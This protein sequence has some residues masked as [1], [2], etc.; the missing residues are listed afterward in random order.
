MRV[1]PLTGEPVKNVIR[2]G[3]LENLWKPGHSVANIGRDVAINSPANRSTHISHMFIYPLA[4]RFRSGKCEEC[5]VCHNSIRNITRNCFI[6]YAISI[7]LL[8][9]SNLLTGLITTLIKCW[10][11]SMGL[12]HN[13]SSWPK[14]HIGSSLI[15]MAKPTSVLFR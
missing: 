14:T 5:M 3:P 9:T 7:S 12:L 15:K 13:N 4:K 8:T 1:Q 10:S 6:F 2:D 11:I